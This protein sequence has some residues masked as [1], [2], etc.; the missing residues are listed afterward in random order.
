MPARFFLMQLFTTKKRDCVNFW[1]LTMSKRKFSS[2]S[3]FTHPFPP[4]FFSLHFG[5]GCCTISLPLS[6]AW[7]PSVPPP[8]PSHVPSNF[9]S[10]ECTLLPFPASLV[11]YSRQSPHWGQLQ[12]PPFLSSCS[13]SLNC[14]VCQPLL[15]LWH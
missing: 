13:C 6:Y 8:S 12:R 1:H 3:Y 15:L 2:I 7:L 11:C 14:I 9:P 5:E 10:L 4:L